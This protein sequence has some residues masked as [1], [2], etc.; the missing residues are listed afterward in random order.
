MRQAVQE[1]EANEEERRSRER[2]LQEELQNK[3]KI[4]R[5]EEVRTPTFSS[6][7]P[8]LRVCR[9]VLF[10]ASILL[11][12]PSLTHSRMLGCSAC[13]QVLRERMSKASAEENA[14]LQQQMA[15][16]SQER[17]EQEEW[18]ENTRKE[19]D[20]YVS[21]LPHSP[22]PPPPASRPLTRSPPPPSHHHHP[23]TLSPTPPT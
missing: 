8:H 19:M 10:A 18:I 5:E 1:A 11:T 4:M 14:A 22:S 7:N 16:L 3:E 15:R 23:L 9:S 21:W 13:T 12:P 2:S 6:P 17:R 20:R